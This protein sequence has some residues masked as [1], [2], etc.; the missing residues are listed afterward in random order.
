MYGRSS[1]S[2][3]LRKKDIGQLGSTPSKR[4]KSTA[5]LVGLPL[6][7]QAPSSTS[8]GNGRPVSPM[9]PAKVR[10]RRE[11]ERASR[12]SMCSM[13]TSRES[14][15]SFAMDTIPQHDMENIPPQLQAPVAGRA[16][17]GLRKSIGP[18]LEIQAPSRRSSLH[19]KVK[20]L[21]QQLPHSRIPTSY[22]FSS[23]KHLR[24]TDW[25]ICSIL[26]CA[27]IC[28]LH[29]RMSCGHRQLVRNVHLPLRR[30]LKI[31][32]LTDRS[33]RSVPC[34]NLPR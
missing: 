21:P 15:V 2:T 28:R 8:N 32:N 3:P 16:S 25:C 5:G 22:P 20:T 33:A 7:S 26:K 1:T 30:C 27:Y 18:L 9:T 24:L 12:G 10:A 6:A 13:P 23:C 34:A 19:Q 17:I 11:S 14:M 29:H 4:S 31:S